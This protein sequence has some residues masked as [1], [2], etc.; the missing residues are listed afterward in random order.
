MPQKQAIY[1]SYGT[2]ERCDEIRKY[3]EDAGVRLTVRDLKTH[4]LAYEELT[5]LLGHL[6]LSHFLNPLAKEYTKFGLDKEMPPR[7]DL[8]KLIAENP[9]LLRRPIIKNARLLTVGCNRKAIADMLQIP[10]NGRAV[11]NPEDDNTRRTNNRKMVSA[12]GK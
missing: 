9:G 2:D 5:R 12:T 1:M 7:R 10:L 8:Y 4:P 6:P 11:E 3:I